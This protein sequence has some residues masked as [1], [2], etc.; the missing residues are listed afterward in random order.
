MNY[1]EVWVNLKDSRRDVEFCR[2]VDAYMGHL[3]SQGR[4]E[5][6]RIT[7]RKFGFGPAGLGEFHVTMAF[8]DLARLDAAFGLVATREGEVERLHLPVYSMVTDFQSALYRGFPDP[9]RG[10]GG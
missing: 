9:E 6:W 8:R 2:A 3:K 10:G 1:Y 7:R 5:W 4:L